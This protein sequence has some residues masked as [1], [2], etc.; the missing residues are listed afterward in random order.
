MKTIQTPAIIEGIRARKDRSLG[1]TV[2]TPELSVQEKAIFMELQGLNIELLITPKD[3]D[4]SPA[5]KIDKDLNQKSQSTRMR[6][7]LFI[8]WK[9]NPQDMD[10]EAF[11]KNKTEKI[12]EHLKSKIEETYE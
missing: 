11:Y 12:I 10:F 2:T 9:Q 3:E 8:L 6:S 7:V 4:G 5:Y 1:L